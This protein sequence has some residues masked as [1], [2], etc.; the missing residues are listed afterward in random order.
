VLAAG[1]LAVALKRRPDSASTRRRP[2][3]AGERSSFVRRR[4]ILFRLRLIH[5][6][7]SMMPALSGRPL[8][9]GRMDDGVLDQW[10]RR[11]GARPSRRSVVGRGLGALAAL[12]AVEPGGGRAT[13]KHHH[14]HSPPRGCDPTPKLCSTSDEYCGGRICVQNGCASPDRPRCCGGIGQWCSGNS[15][16]CCGHDLD[17]V[18]NKCVYAPR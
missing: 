8:K 5:A 10:A 18:A 17:C 4:S 12:A 1:A 3:S 13:P 2:A 14:H 16:E 9:E 7:S 11:V 6:A 15:C